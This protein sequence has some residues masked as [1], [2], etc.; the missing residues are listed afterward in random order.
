MA[1]GQT[2]ITPS[3]NFFMFI[4]STPDDIRT[5]V[6]HQ[7]T[8]P[9]FTVGFVPTMGALH[10]GHLSLMRQAKNECDIVVA[11]IFVNPLQFNVQSDYDKYPRTTDSDLGQCE[12]MGVDA[13]FLPTR[14]IMYPAGHET[15]VLPG[16]TAEPMEGA[17]RPGHFAGVTTIVTKLFL[18]VQ[19]DRAYFGQKDYQQLA[20]VKRMVLDLDMG[21]TVI[22]SP[23]VREQDGLAM[24]SRNV[25]LNPDQRKASSIIYRGLQKAHD[26]FN[27]GERNPA[28]LITLVSQ[29]YDSESLAR[30][31][32]VSIADA[33]TLQPVS[34]VIDRAV[35]AVAVWFGDVRL[36][37]NIELQP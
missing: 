30:T 1:R 36:I 5:W 14:E 17:G 31:E 28:Q 21:I 16:R 29:T 32:Y 23:T 15:T 25:R 22:G 10:D 8:S 4:A 3:T 19:P 27:N 6:R 34:E 9:D 13:V 18:S 24:S 37:D 33:A 12:L 2:Q 35:I 26:A 7:R 11:S 20:V